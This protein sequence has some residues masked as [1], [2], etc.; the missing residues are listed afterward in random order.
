M[1]GSNLRCQFLQIVFKTKNS[2]FFDDSVCFFDPVS[3]LFC[4][5]EIKLIE[6]PNQVRIYKVSE[7]NCVV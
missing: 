4:L 2:V 3:F 1:I 7:Q 5:G 6:I